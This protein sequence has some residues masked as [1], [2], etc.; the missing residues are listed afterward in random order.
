[1]TLSS[2]NASFKLHISGWDD[3]RV[4]NL[5]SENWS[6]CEFEPVV[7]TVPGLRNGTLSAAQLVAKVECGLQGAG[8]LRLWL[9]KLVHQDEPLM[10]VC[11]STP[12]T[13]NLSRR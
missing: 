13:Q 5:Q 4:E 3:G 1:V 9:L 8:T 11:M 2:W 12:P 6:S 7:I 10:R